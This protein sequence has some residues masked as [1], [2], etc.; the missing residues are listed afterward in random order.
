MVIGLLTVL[1]I[2]HYTFNLPSAYL[3]MDNII[4][5]VI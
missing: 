3:L 1:N 4:N 2:L 5:K